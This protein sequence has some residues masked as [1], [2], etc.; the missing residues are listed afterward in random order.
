MGIE[1]SSTAIS[2]KV[3]VGADKTKIKSSDDANPDGGGFSEILTSLDSP[4]DQS[5]V[6]NKQSESEEKR[7]LAE[8]SASGSTIP[9]TPVVPTEIAMLLAQANEVGND[10]LDASLTSSTSNVPTEMAMLLAQAGEMSGSQLNVSVEGGRLLGK[11]GTM[12]STANAQSAEKLEV[13]NGLGVTL[14]GDKAEDF[15]QSNAALLDQ[16]ASALLGQARKTKVAELQSA[17]AASLVEARVLKQSSMA[18]A[19]T[20]E[21]ELSGALVSSGLADEVFR[22]ID[23][24]GSKSLTQPTVSGLEGVWGAQTFQVGNHIDAPSVIADVPMLSP[25]QAVAD[26]VSYWVT[27]GVQNA[28]LKLDGFDGEPI[29]VSISLKGDEAQINFRTDQPEVQKI[30]E[31]AVAHLKELL[32]SE[33]LVLTGVSVGGSGQQGSGAQ[34]QRNRP[35]DV[36]QASIVM[37]NERQT[38][39]Q[40][41]VNKPVG[42]ALDLYV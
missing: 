19:M 25:E 8:N 14:G 3:G 26:T 36:R 24:A 34:E 9:A 16:S 21:T 29:A 5:E 4:N 35:D 1:L 32:S 30:L 28:E 22:Q 31:G 6:A 10:K 11:A 20:R 15:K 33:G 17:A 13:A 41:R 23:R 27:Q 2:P 12:R 38:E 42:R 39:S 40:V 37:S 7:K 18:D